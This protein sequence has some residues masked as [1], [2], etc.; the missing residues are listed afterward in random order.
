MRDWFSEVFHGTP[1]HLGIRMEAFRGSQRH[2]E[3]QEVVAARAD[4][5][6]MREPRQVLAD[7]LWAMREDAGPE[8]PVPPLEE[9]MAQ[10]MRRTNGR[11]NPVMVEGAYV[12]VSLMLDMAN[13]A[14]D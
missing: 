2:R 6:A 10:V 12:G 7:T 3:I 1:P 13:D 8:S 4:A 11:L 14:S 5:Q 9:F